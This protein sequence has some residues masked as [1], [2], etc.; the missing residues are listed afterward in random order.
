MVR[1]PWCW[2]LA[3]AVACD[4][5]AA[6]RDDAGGGGGDG[7]DGDGADVTPPRVAAIGAEA[8]AWLHEPIEVSFDEP[9]T[10]AGASVV[11]VVGGQEVAGAITLS[12]DRTVVIELDAGARGVGA[13]EVRLDGVADLAGNG[14]VEPVVVERA[15]AAWSRPPVERG[16]AVGAPAVT[17]STGGAVYAAWI[18]GGE[19]VASVHEHGAWRPLGAGIGAAIGGRGGASRGRAPTATPSSSRIANTRRAAVWTAPMAVHPPG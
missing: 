9:V 4:G 1:R 7:G 10:I 16:P 8:D 17:A 5:G 6:A 19:L 2:A 15:I 13:L 14:I 12:G 11:A 3:L 18:A